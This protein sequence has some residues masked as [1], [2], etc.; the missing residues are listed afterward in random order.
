MQ[1]IAEIRELRGQL[2][3]LDKRTAVNEA[4]VGVSTPRSG[5]MFEALGRESGGA[6]K[7]PETRK[8]KKRKLLFRRGDG[9]LDE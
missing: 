3:S 5:S 8:S 6:I 7:T 1:Y 2:D 9:D 4:A